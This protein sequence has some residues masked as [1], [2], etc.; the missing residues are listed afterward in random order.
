MQLQRVVPKAAARRAQPSEPGEPRPDEQGE[1]SHAGA[2]RDRM[3][4]AERADGGRFLLD[5]RLLATL[6]RG[7]GFVFREESQSVKLTH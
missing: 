3:D 5:G 2:L 4:D 7:K 1:L 6:F